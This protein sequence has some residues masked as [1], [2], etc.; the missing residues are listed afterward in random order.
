MSA[1]KT[2]PVRLTKGQELKDFLIKFAKDK[3]LSA[4]FILTC[5]GSVSCATLR[6]AKPENGDEKVRILKLHFDHLSHE[7][8]LNLRIFRYNILTSILKF[9]PL[10]E[11]WQTQD[12]YTLY[13]DVKMGQQ[14]LDM[15][16]EI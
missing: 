13:L 3:N 8:L 15:S 5:C 7:I 11:L 12:I 10:S 2:Y 14:F 16:W 4:P 6:F 1:L 9:V